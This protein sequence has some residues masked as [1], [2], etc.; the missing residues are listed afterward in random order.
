LRSRDEELERVE[1]ENETRSPSRQLS[2]QKIQRKIDKA[3][4][5]R[6]AL[7]EQQQELEAL[8]AEKAALVPEVDEA[9]VEP[10]S[11]VAATPAAADTNIKDFKRGFSEERIIE[12]KD[13]FV[14]IPVTAQYK[15]KFFDVTQEEL[16]DEDGVVLGVRD[17]LQLKPEFTNQQKIPAKEKAGVIYRGMSAGEYQEFLR[18]GEIQSK[19]TFN[20]G[21][22]QQGLTYYSVSP[23]Q[24]ANYASWFAPPDFKPTFEK[25][26]YV[27][28]IKRP[29]ED[30]IAQVDGTSDQE[31][32]VTGAILK[33][34]I[35]A[36]YQGDVVQHVSR[37]QTLRRG[38]QIFAGAATSSVLW[39]ELTPAL[40]IEEDVTADIPAT[41]AR[42]KFVK[43][44]AKVLEDLGVDITVA[45][46]RGFQA[47]VTA[48]L[49]VSEGVIKGKTAV[50][51]ALEAIPGLKEINEGKVLQR[52]INRVN[53]A[54]TFPQ[55]R[56]VA[57]TVQ[58]RALDAI[59]KEQRLT[60]R[61]YRLASCGGKTQI[62]RSYLS[63]LKK[64]SI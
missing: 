31:I 16:K 1:T 58:S 26:A 50:H 22:D 62:E 18:T 41:P 35:V 37:Q 4:E 61:R 19:G 30:R 25:P 8:P 17:V 21:L 48:G 28:A 36:V 11:K 38:E 42:G 51:K 7:V 46:S 63:K 64:S 39:T 47:G 6:D 3:I 24:A 44:K 15:P 59:A 55:L 23:N 45:A 2:T 56:R 10:I 27:I 54:V 60:S 9:L 49:K 53:K 33:A 40:K 13:G 12:D 43:V 52:L 32:G 34:D 14:D 57:A 5:R 20:I 29:A